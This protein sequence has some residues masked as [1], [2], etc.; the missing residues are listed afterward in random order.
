MRRPKQKLPPIAVE[1]KSEKISVSLSDALLG[2]IRQFSEFF[3]QQSGQKPSSLNAVIV[4]V[5]A[6]YLQEH[7]DFQRWRKGSG[8]EINGAAGAA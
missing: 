7:R 3:A 8:V 2:E 6:G 5:L 4:G 1:D